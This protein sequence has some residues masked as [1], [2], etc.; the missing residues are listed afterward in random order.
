MVVLFIIAT[1]GICLLVDHLLRRSETVND[2]STK[3]GSL[4]YEEMPSVQTPA[5]MYAGGFQIDSTRHYHPGHA[6]AVRE[7]DETVRVGIDDFA[8]RLLGT[9]QA[10]E[11]PAAGTSLVQ[12]R[13]GWTLTT[14]EGVVPILAPVTGE[15]TEI[16]PAI[17]DM[18]SQIND[19]P[20]EGG[21]LFKL[22]SPTLRDNLNNLLSGDPVRQWMEALA[23]RLR[24]VTTGE[25]VLT[26]QDGGEAVHDLSALML[27]DRWRDAVR[28]FMLTD[29]LD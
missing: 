26:F 12:G 1:V 2:K 7:D 24:I 6:W 14:P 23:A 3:S 28:T 15:V 16:N 22:R 21:W 20:Y 4:P 19:D 25:V 9:I 11:L 27:E 18:P 13:E 29:I 8:A 10:A 5:R 17:A